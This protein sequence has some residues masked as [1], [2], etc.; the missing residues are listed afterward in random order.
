MGYY[1]LCP[2][3]GAS[4]DPGEHC[5]CDQEKREKPDLLKRED[6]EECKKTA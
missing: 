5:D 2:I 6:E 1:N 4:L 3:C